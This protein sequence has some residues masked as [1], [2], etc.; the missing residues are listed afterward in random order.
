MIP[1]EIDPQ[2]REAP[3]EQLR[4]QVAGAVADGTLQPGESLPTVRALAADLGLAANTVARAYR[5]LEAAGVVETQGRRGT[6][7][8][9]R[10]LTSPD[11]RAA[12]ERA[13]ATFVEDARRLGL[14]REE[15]VRLVQERWGR[16]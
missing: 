6:F 9:S 16:S 2:S 8:A 13:V 5:E 11:T 1:L 12:A 15:T 7:V 10:A 14:S 4:R 3:F